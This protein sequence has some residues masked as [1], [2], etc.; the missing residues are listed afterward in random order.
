MSDHRPPITLQKAMSE[1]FV[2][3]VAE[4]GLRKMTVEDYREDLTLFLQYFPSKQT[5]EDLSPKT[6]PGDFAVME[7]NAQK[8]PAS[9]ARRVSTLYN[10]LL[11]LSKEGYIDPPEASMARP[12]LSKKLPEVLSFEEINALL[13]QPDPSVEA[14]ARDKAML[15]TMY[16]TGLRVSELCALRLP[17][18]DRDHRLIRVI[19]GKGGKPRIVPISEFALSWLTRYIDIFRI[20]NKGHGEKEVFLSRQGRAVTRQCFFLCVKKYAEMA[21]IDPVIVSPHT[22]RHSFA[23]H[24]LENGA[25]LRAVQEMLGHSHLSTT[26]IYTHVSSR[27][28]AEAYSTYLGED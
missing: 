19:S 24:L 22:L 26:Q 10:F 17:D 21:G 9:I 11:F 13:D 6:D 12:K 14:G 25:S 5:T 23:T 8:S 18:V 27:R 16:A 3:L 7:G 20:E 2:Y 15:E 28:I 1:Y 4:K